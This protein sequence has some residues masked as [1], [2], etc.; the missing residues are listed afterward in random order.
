MEQLMA[1]TYAPLKA[2]GSL[3]TGVVA[4]YREFLRANRVKGAFVNGSTGDFASL[5]TEERKE[6]IDAWADGRPDGFTLV[7]HVG[8]TNLREA[9][10]LAAHSNGRVDA[11]AALAPYYFR[12][13]TLDSL[14]TYCR[15]IA[16]CAPDTPF[17]YYHIPV[18]T[19]ADFAM[20]DFLER[21]ERDIPTFA[22]IKYSDGNL[23]DFGACVSYG[24]GDYRILFGVDEMLVDS[25]AAGATGWVGSTY[26]H[27][28]PLYQ[29]LIR[30]YRKGETDA[31]RQLQEKAV[32]FVQ[33]L[34]GQCG[35]NGAGKSFLREVGLDLGP[36]R[37]PHRSL[38]EE[39]RAAV[40]EVLEQL[41]ILPHLSTVPAWPATT[42]AE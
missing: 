8:H 5:S 14:L 36:S 31:A 37:F 15:E 12:I 26:N 28:A 6:L 21:A 10:E 35:F 34:D 24:D 1:A 2:D 30:L 20:R 16:V 38:T 41:G 27:L 25:L 13:R 3:N 29:T 4:R 39:Q 18:L 33:T 9:R 11:V 17:Y 32:R 22:G 7:N 23:T 42:P 40:M 19:G